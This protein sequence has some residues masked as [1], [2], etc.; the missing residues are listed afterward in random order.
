LNNPNELNID[1]NRTELQG[2]RDFY[3]REIEPQIVVR[4]DRW[5]IARRRLLLFGPTGAV[6]TIVVGW[7]LFRSR[8]LGLVH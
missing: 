2:F 3:T 1:E 5:R 7:M 6:A 4:R 8:G